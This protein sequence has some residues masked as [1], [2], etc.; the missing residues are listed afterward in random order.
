MSELVGM[1]HGEKI[2]DNTI[3]PFIVTNQRQPASH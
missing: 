2:N 1:A 3:H